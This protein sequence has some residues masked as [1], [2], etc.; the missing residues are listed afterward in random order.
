MP[1]VVNSRV[2]RSDHKR[3][4]SEDDIKIITEEDELSKLGFGA[5]KPEIKF[6]PRKPKY[7]LSDLI[8]GGDRHVVP[9]EK[10]RI[11]KYGKLDIK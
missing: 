5:A 7:G 8:N 6:E 3:D 9:V 4:K 1:S 11:Y 10:K 2:D